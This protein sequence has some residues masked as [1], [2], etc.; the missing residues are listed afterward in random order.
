[1]VHATY[2]GNLG[3]RGMFGN[4]GFGP[5]MTGTTKI[6]ANKVVYTAGDNVRY[7]NSRVPQ[8][9]FNWTETALEFNVM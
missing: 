2:V 3:P 7:R 9:R 4:Y 1:M 5:G 8:P 6:D